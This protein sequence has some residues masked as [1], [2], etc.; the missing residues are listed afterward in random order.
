VTDLLGAGVR[1]GDLYVDHGVSM[2]VS[3]RQLGQAVVAL[4]R[5]HTLA[6]VMPDR[7]GRSTQNML[8]FAETPRGERSRAAGA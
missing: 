6:I 2:G 5:G 1:R 7:P 3:R 4:E 8:A